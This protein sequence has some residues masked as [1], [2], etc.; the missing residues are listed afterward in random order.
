M[1]IFKNF[2]NGMIDLYDSIW[3]DVSK[4]RG[5]NKRLDIIAE[6]IVGL[7]KSYCPQ[8]TGKLYDSIDKK[9]TSNENGY[10]ISIYGEGRRYG[11]FVEYGTGVRGENDPH[12]Q[13]PSSWKY[14]AYF[15]ENGIDWQGKRY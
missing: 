4:V 1:P 5:I 3:K 2:Y 8:R 7:A 14:N 11:R 13:P 6:F 10:I 12:P 9:K 15:D